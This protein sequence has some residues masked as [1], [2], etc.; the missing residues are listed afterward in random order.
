MN[1]GKKT[2]DK[3]RMKRIKQKKLFGMVQNREIFI[4]LCGPTPADY[5]Q[6]I[7]YRKFK[8]AYLLDT[9][10]KNVAKS[11]LHFRGKEKQLR[12]TGMKANIL[13]FLDLDAFFD[14]DFCGSIKSIEKDLPK[15]VKTKEFCLTVAL[16]PISE[17]NTINIIKKYTSRLYT[18]RVYKDRGTA[19][20]MFYFPPI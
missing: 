3:S 14:L 5:L 18:Q 10:P 15:I 8:T 6:V 19:M 9:N 17:L 11:N 1:T 20:I 2:Y 4:G 13:D 16:R 7:N 12:V